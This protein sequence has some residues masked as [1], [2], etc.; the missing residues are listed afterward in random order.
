MKC[1]REN[2]NKTKPGFTG[3]GKRRHG[4]PRCHICHTRFSEEWWRKPVEIEFGVIEI[5]YRC[6]ECE[7]DLFKKTN[8]Y[9]EEEE[10]FLEEEEIE[11]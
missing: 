5:L 11:D 4:R 9:S 3:R 8:E 10:E 7:F 1:E 2:T 6:D